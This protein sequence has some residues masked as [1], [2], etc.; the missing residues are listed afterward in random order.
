MTEP[1]GTAPDRSRPI[2]VGTDG[3][4]HAR[5]AVAFALY[6]AQLR[7]VGVRAVCAYDF[8]PDRYSAYGWMTVPNPASELF[9]QM[10]DTALADVDRTVEEL[11]REVGGPYVEVE[12]VAEQGRPAEVLLEASKNAGLLV[13]GS[14][15]SGLWGRL[16]LGSTSTEVVHHAHIPVMVVPAAPAEEGEVSPA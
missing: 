6:E 11:R 5:K 3:S 1:H 14:R 12:V 13:V 8:T 7:G 9:T 15:G 10:R 4:A 16:T 2:V